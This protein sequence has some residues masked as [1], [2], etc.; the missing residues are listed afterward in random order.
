MKRPTTYN[1]AESVETMP[2]EYSPFLPLILEHMV[3]EERNRIKHQ[4]Q[5]SRSYLCDREKRGGQSDTQGLSSYKV[6]LDEGQQGSRS[7]V[8]EITSPAD[9]YVGGLAN[10]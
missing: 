7:H 3:E 4:S 10:A 5:L 8:L 9:A 1:L 6:S 2:H